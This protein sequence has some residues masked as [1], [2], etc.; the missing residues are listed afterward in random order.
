MI[1]TFVCLKYIMKTTPTS[2]INLKVNLGKVDYQDQWRIFCI[3]TGKRKYIGQQ[4]INVQI[5]E[6]KTFIVR[7]EGIPKGS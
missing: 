1:I 2:A 3:Y 7:I 5:K 6:S 4:F